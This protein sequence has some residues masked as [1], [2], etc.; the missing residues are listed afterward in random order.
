[1]T[2]VL[3]AEINGILVHVV[4]FKALL[5]HITFADA[6]SGSFRPVKNVICE[7]NERVRP[8]PP[9][10]AFLI[11]RLKPKRATLFHCLTA[12]VFS[13]FIYAD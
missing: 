11:R 4:I 5:L 7:S 8:I 9:N 1:M 3:F 6:G 10:T 12:Q 13:V 2:R